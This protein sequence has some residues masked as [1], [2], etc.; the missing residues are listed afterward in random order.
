MPLLIFFLLVLLGLTQGSSSLEAQDL[1]HWQSLQNRFAPLANYYLHTDRS[2][3]EPDEDLFFRIYATERNLQGLKSGNLAVLRLYNPQGLILEEHYLWLKGGINEGKIH[4]NSDYAGGI[5]RLELSLP[6]AAGWSVMPAYVKEITLQKVQIPRV[7]LQVEYQRKAY[8]P[9]DTVE[10]ELRLRDGKGQPLAGKGFEYEVNLHG[11]PYLKAQMNCDGEGKALIRFVLPSSLRNNNGILNI[12]L[13][14]LG[15]QEALSRSLPL[16]LNNID[17]QFL[18]EGGQALVGLTNHY[19]FKALNEWGKPADVAGLIRD[20][21]GEV[22][23]EFKSYHQGLGGVWL[24]PES[25]QVYW[26]ELTEPKGNTQRFYLPTAMSFGANLQ[27]MERDSESISL[28]LQATS[29]QALNLSL[30]I[31]DSVYFEAWYQVGPEAYWVNLALADLP[32]GVG[33]WTLTDVYGRPLATRL[34]FFHRLRQAKVEAWPSDWAYVLN[35]FE[36]QQTG[37]IEVKVANPLTQEALAGVRMS[38][39]LV[40]EDNYSFADDKQGHILSALLLENELSGK[41]EEPNFFFHPTAPKADSALDYL[42]LTQGW[43]KYPWAELLNKSQYYWESRWAGL[44]RYQEL[45]FSLEKIDNQVVSIENELGETE[46]LSPIYS[47]GE[48]AYYLYSLAESPRFLHLNSPN[49]KRTYAF[50][51]DALGQ[52]FWAFDA[53]QSYHYLSLKGQIQNEKNRQALKHLVLRLEDSTGLVAGTALSDEKGHF[54]FEGLNPNMSYRLR[55]ER[56][57]GSFSFGKQKDNFNHSFLVSLKAMPDRDYPEWSIEPLFKPKYDYWRKQIDFVQEQA[58]KQ[59]D[60]LEAP[61]F[62][63]QEIERLATRN[64][65]DVIS[66]TAGVNRKDKSEQYNASGSRPRPSNAPSAKKKSAE[67]SK[68]N[69]V[70]VDGARRIGESDKMTQ[71]SLDDEESD[72]QMANVMGE[73]ESQLSFIEKETEEYRAEELKQ[74]TPFN[75]DLNPSPPKPYPGMAPPPPP[76][77][78]APMMAQDE[79]VAFDPETFGFYEDKAKPSPQGGTSAH[80]YQWKINPNVFVDAFARPVQG[81]EA[82][83]DAFDPK[84]LSRQKM[85][86]NRELYAAINY[87]PQYFDDT[88]EA[89]AEN[90]SKRF[91]T[92]AWDTLYTDEQGQAQAEFNLGHQAGS[93]RFILEGLSPQGLLLRYD[94]VFAI[95]APV[96]I[97][98]QIPSSLNQGDQAFARFSIQ[99]RLKEKL[100]LQY[101]CPCLKLENKVQHIR[102]QDTL[103]V[104]D[105]KLNSKNSK[106]RSNCKLQVKILNADGQCLSQYEQNISLQEEI[107][108]AKLQLLGAD[109][110]VKTRVKLG[111]INKKSLQ[112]RFFTLNLSEQITQAITQLQNQNTVNFEQLCSQT[113]AH[114][115]ILLNQNNRLS[116]KQLEQHR[117]KALQGFEQLQAYINPQGQIGWFDAQSN[118]DLNLNAY[119]LLLF[120]DMQQLGLIQALAYQNLEN[121]FFKQVATEL[122]KPQRNAALSYWIYALNYLSPQ[123]LNYLNEEYFAKTNPEQSSPY[124]LALSYL[125]LKD[126]ANNP[127]A[128]G[129]SIEKTL[130]QQIEQ[131][132]K[133]KRTTEP[134]PFGSRGVYQDLETQALCLLALAESK[135]RPDLQSRLLAELRQNSSQYDNLGQ[136]KIWILKALLARYQQ[137][138]AQPQTVSLY[139][140]DKARASLQ[141]GGGEQNINARRYLSRKKTHTIELRSDKAKDLSTEGFGFAMSWNSKK[142]PRSSAEAPVELLL[143][144]AKQGKKNKQVGQVQHLRLALRNRTKTSQKQLVAIV[145]LPKG[146]SLQPKQL[147]DL[148]EQKRIDY[149]QIKDDKLHLYLAELGPKERRNL[150]LDLR[151]EQAGYFKHRAACV[152]PLYQPNAVYWLA[153]KGGLR[154]KS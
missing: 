62:V 64:I 27:V 80:S 49:Q 15:L 33:Q 42:L 66:T 71:W 31:Q 82:F 59:T 65:N 4:F 89:I 114:V 107:F 97:Q 117:Q 91:N 100:Y 101:N 128:L 99:K 90:R 121:Y 55:V 7:L 56:E 95:F 10:A 111:K 37:N 143:S 84:S 142:A 5:Y 46:L 116:N 69:D 43:R 36:G 12:R 68:S 53:K 108:Y 70:Y 135:K 153:L 103:L 151:V 39:A 2:L 22:V 88:Y 35:P 23:A 133:S 139:L 126:K 140:N 8:G 146:L 29:Q 127:S 57:E 110:G 86:F 148:Q 54:C 28:K 9:R 14:H 115:L 130:I 76:P 50:K 78:P 98:A 44:P 94:T 77:P 152:Y 106:P 92:L 87:Q 3:Y 147:K 113:Y 131:G 105:L 60:S 75:Q 74:E 48:A 6:W 154:I 73:L 58:D 72:M 141:A 149:Y 41:I 137:N 119:A 79:I 118:Y 47:Q 45:N 17:L 138:Q 150:A 129:Q 104:F 21:R 124:T 112:A 109:R 52:P 85:A 102:E 13:N 67:R 24:E 20:S 134:T 40:R 38:L 16:S 63:I 61:V 125:S 96:E 1:R 123:P 51:T 32:Q 93:Y 120:R 144:F 30:R 34:S 11:E 26:A 136:T 19:A 81:S 25:G 18:P 122:D 132:F 145:P 83:Q